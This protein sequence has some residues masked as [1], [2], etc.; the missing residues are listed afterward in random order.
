MIGNS[1]RI[2]GEIIVLPEHQPIKGL[3]CPISLGTIQHPVYLR[4]CEHVFERDVIEKFFRETLLVE[5]RVGDKVYMK[6]EVKCPQCRHIYSISKFQI[7]LGN[8]AQA[9]DAFFK[10]IF[11]VPMVTIEINDRLEKAKNHEKII[12]NGM[13]RIEEQ[14][15]IIEEQ[16]IQILHKNAQIIQIQNTF[17]QTIRIKDDEINNL[18]E[19]I[20]ADRKINVVIMAGGFGTFTVGCILIFLARNNAITM[21]AIPQMPALPEIP[22]I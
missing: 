7:K 12:K 22:K 10:K 11:I 18:K 16:N 17:E 19:E 20:Q 5:R 8:R 21:P 1:T 2:P 9:I 14:N 3:K 13:R 4:G 6:S 15:T